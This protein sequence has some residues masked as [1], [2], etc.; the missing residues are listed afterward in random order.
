MRTKLCGCL[1]VLLLVSVSQM[2]G[3]L[4]E[5]LFFGPTFSLT[6][7]HITDEEGFACLHLQYTTKETVTVKLFNNRGT[8]VDTTLLLFGSNETMLYLASYHEPVVPGVYTL[9]VY[10]D[11]LEDVFEEEVSIEQGSAQIV[12]FEQQ[13]WQREGAAWLLC[14]T[15]TVMNRGESPLYPQTLEMSVAGTSFSSALLPDVLP[16]GETRDIVGYVVISERIEGDA[17]VSLHDGTGEELDSFQLSLQMESTIEE[18]S[19][20][21][22]HQFENL[23]LFIPYPHLLHEYYQGLERLENEDYSVYV[24]DPFDDDYLDLVVDQLLSDVSMED[25]VEQVEVLASFVQHLSYR[26]DINGNLSCEYPRYP[27]ETLFDDGGGGDCED[28]AI[29]AA[30]LL[31]QAGFEV[32]LLRL[33]NHMAVGVKLSQPLSSH[34][35]YTGEYYFLETTTKNQKVG[36]IPTEYVDDAN[37]SVYPIADRPVVLH[38]WKNNSITIYKNTMYGDFVRVTAVVQN[39]GSAV[40]R[41]VAVTAGFYTSGGKDRESKTKII[42]VIQPG[43]KEQISLMVNIPDEG[44]TWFSTRVLL[45]NNLVDEKKSATSFP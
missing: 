5:E 3:C 13:W 26:E 2:T 14:L 20:N 18:T 42:P 19:F 44:P 22:R 23:Q 17:V 10:N 41:D 21:W 12:T 16:P 1:I 29:V 4:M 30:A 33:T 27:L 34:T 37:L 9:K 43:G 40:A 39:A 36:V 7:W 8:L 24:F 32:A 38:A 11:E 31:S 28:K 45:D 25:E 35:T 6:S 15:M